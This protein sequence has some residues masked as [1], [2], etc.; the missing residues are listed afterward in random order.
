[1]CHCLADVEAPAIECP[2]I[3]ET[4]QPGERWVVIDLS[5]TKMSDNSG[6]G[7][8]NITIVGR[9][10]GD[11]FYRGTRQLRYEARDA[12]GNVAVC[13]RQITVRGMSTLSEL[14]NNNIK[15]YI[16]PMCG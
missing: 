4:L 5:P 13:Q 3:S 10:D 11:V 16:G 8:I 12:A 2:A 6:L 1:M 15:T 14:I 7:S 9:P